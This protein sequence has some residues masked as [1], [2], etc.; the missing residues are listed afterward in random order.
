MDGYHFHNTDQLHEGTRFIVESFFKELESGS[1]KLPD[2][3]DGAMIDVPI[4]DLGIHHPVVITELKISTVPYFPEATE[5]EDGGMN[6]RGGEG[7]M[8]MR[9]RGPMLGLEGGGQAGV[10]KPPEPWKLRRYD[11]RIQFCWQPMPRG[12]RQEMMAEREKQKE[13]PQTAATGDEATTI[14]DST[15]G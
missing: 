10:E 3:P 5:E 13:N 6:N 8:M 11:F 9:D 4:K 1:V 7:R 2:G 15:S 12:K 14:S